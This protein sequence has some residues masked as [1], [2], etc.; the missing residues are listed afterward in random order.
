MAI[1]GQNPA[2]GT[3]G[4]PTTFD[5][6][7]VCAECGI[8][9]PEGTLLCKACGNNLRE[10]RTRRLTDGQHVSGS[11]VEGS[12][13]LKKAL[14]ALGVLIVI[15]VAI[16]NTRIESFL[17]SVQMPS[18]SGAGLMWQGPNS[19][20]YDEL[21]RELDA[22]PITKEEIEVALKELP[23]SEGYDGRYVLMQKRSDG[24]GPELGTAFV[25]QD[26]DAIR[27]VAKLVDNTEIRGD[28]HIDAGGLLRAQ[29]SAAVRIDGEC[30][31]AQGFAARRDDGFE[32]RGE[33]G[34]SFDM[35]FGAMAYRIPRL[36]E[37]QF[38]P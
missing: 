31:M 15:W 26:G 21:S 16:N 4:R 33:S 38:A 37:F 23:V 34:H 14:G 36:G 28:A 7:A 30:Y 6:D 18:K 24:L 10:Q 9:N 5:A 29:N 2:G 1:Q 27:F 3:Q 12:R 19:S 11:V 20:L 13:W 35:S 32:C 25:R 22:N 17:V 8:V